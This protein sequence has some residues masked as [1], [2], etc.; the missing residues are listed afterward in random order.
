MA[1]I[2]KPEIMKKEMVTFSLSRHIGL[3]MKYLSNKSVIVEEVL[4]ENM[5]RINGGNIEMAIKARE[6]QIR[7]LVV[8]TLRNSN[9]ELLENLNILKELQEAAHSLQEMNS[10]S[11]STKNELE[12]IAQSITNISVNLSNGTIKSKLVDEICNKIYSDTE[13][14]SKDMFEV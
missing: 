6:T 14:M 9:A 12:G 11:T 3:A 13:R 8:N 2:K 7:D 1:R 5:D 4:L 10:M